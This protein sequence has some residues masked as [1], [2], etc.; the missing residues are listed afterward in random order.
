MHPTDSTGP[1][2]TP[3]VDLP[4]RP[5]PRYNLAVVDTASKNSVALVHYVFADKGD[6]QDIFTEYL[7]Q[8]I[9]EQ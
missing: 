6:V 2:D 5:T 9:N 1:P 3:P 4:P 7:H 8:K